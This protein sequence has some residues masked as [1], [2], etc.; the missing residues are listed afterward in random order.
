[1]NRAQR[2]ESRGSGQTPARRK[3]GIVRPEK[4]TITR[5]P[6]ADLPAYTGESLLVIM[7][8]GRMIAA[9]FDQRQYKLCYLRSRY[10]FLPEFFN[11]VEWWV[12]VDEIKEQGERSK[13]QR[14]I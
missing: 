10:P 2:A 1:M 9:Y 14:A 4:V 8:R 5:Y 3:G 13:E 7:A 11:L 6:P 12:I